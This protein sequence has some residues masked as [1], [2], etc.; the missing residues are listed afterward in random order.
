[1]KKTQAGFTLIEIAI[2]LVIIGLLLGGVLKGQ[3]MINNSKVRNTNNSMDGIAA[4]I[5]SYQDR[6]NALPGDDPNA[7]G[8]WG[9]LVVDGDGNGV[10][11][12]AYDSIDGS[13]DESAMLW[14]HLRQAGL[15]TGAPTADNTAI[16][17][18]THALGG[19]FGVETV[20]GTGANDATAITAGTIIC[21]T[22]IEDK[23]GEILD[24]KL[25]DGD[26]GAGDIQNT[27]GAY[28]VVNGAV[29][30]LCRRI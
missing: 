17:P 30:D 14:E 29:D 3:E 21:L 22:T 24:L 28:D 23:F 18:P 5:Y 25:D 8:R 13:A 15:I 20:G 10:I 4:A 26:G 9:G 7:L 2:V 12:G 19:V 27:T 11:D 6:Y 1:M 16:I